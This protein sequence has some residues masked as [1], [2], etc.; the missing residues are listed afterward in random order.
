MAIATRALRSAPRRQQHVELA[1][2]GRQAYL[3]GQVEQVVGGV[4]HRG[5]HHDHVVAGLLGLHD[6]LG[7]APD[8]LGVAH[9]GSAVLLHDERHC[10]PFRERGRSPI[11]IRG[12]RTCFCRVTGGNVRSVADSPADRTAD[13]R[14]PIHPPI[15]ARWSPW[16]FDPDAVVDTEQLTALL[17]AARWA[18]T[19]GHRQPV[20]FVV[21]VRRDPTF[22]RLSGLLRRG[23]SYA[24]MRPA[25]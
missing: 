2:R 20:R 3:P 18:P 9:R 1:R 25:H 10:L 19:W 6:A 17:E 14:V 23:N 13:T 4:T 22:A 12:G 8:P 24:R 11:R 21:G 15:A 5:D 7:D 16:A